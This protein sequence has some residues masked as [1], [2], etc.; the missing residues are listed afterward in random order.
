MTMATS[1]VK[2]AFCE[3]CGCHRIGA[4]TGGAIAPQ[5][6][7]LQARSAV[8]LNFGHAVMVDDPDAL[9]ALL[10]EELRP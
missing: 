2:A 8:S 3:H 6:A 1:S 4:S 5:Q 7:T 9:A 10:L